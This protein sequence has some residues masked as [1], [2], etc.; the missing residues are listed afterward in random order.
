[1]QH[2]LYQLIFFPQRY[3]AI[4]HPL[5][6]FKRP[7]PTRGRFTSWQNKMTAQSAAQVDFDARIGAAPLQRVSWVATDLLLFTTYRVS[8]AALECAEMDRHKNTD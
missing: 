5:L 6:V 4:A 8:N 2:A 7:H 3:R 1:M